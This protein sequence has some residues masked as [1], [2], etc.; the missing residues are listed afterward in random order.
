MTKAFRQQNHQSFPVKD[1]MSMIER[2]KNKITFCDVVKMIFVYH[3]SCL[4]RHRKELHRQEKPK[5]SATEKENKRE[6]YNKLKRQ[7]E[8]ENVDTFGLSGP[9]WRKQPPWG[10]AN[11]LGVTVYDDDIR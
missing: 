7:K 2:I 11:H 1:L 4:Y 5:R 3:C 6:Y 10:R 9:L 8:I